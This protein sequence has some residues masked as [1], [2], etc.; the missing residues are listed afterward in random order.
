MNEITKEDIK[1]LE[2]IE[3]IGVR[4]NATLNLKLTKAVKDI[5]DKLKILEKQ[6]LL[7]Y[8]D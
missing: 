4:N 2:Y 1:F 3:R 8:N 7:L 6:G 5:Q